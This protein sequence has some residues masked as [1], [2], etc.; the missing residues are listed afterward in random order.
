MHV[1]GAGYQSVLEE[2]V[3]IETAEGMQM[4]CNTS[5]LNA[6]Y[7]GIILQNILLLHIQARETVVEWLKDKE[8]FRGEE[9]N[10]MRLGLCSRS[11]DVIEPVL[12]PQWW[13]ACKG[14]ADDACVAVR[15]GRI[16]II[17]AEFEGTWFRCA[18]PQLLTQCCASIAAR[19]AQLALIQ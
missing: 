19:I 1:L 16:Q 18:G 14:M 7:E 10:K 12:K 13:V 5:H 9:G 8:L 3:T 17:P 15:D 2:S 6:E 4:L 11:K